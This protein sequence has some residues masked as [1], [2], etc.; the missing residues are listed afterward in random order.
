MLADDEPGTYA[1]AARWLPLDVVEAIEATLPCQMFR[2]HQW[3]HERDE[4][5]SWTQPAPVRV[6]EWWMCPCGTSTHQDPEGLR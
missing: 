2:D 6:D 1:A 5:M 4:V 3:T